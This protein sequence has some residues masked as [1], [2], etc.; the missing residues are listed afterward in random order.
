[1]AG[2]N[3]VSGLPCV[4]GGIVPTGGDRTRGIG[5]GEV[6]NG[7]GTTGGV[8]NTA[9]S[10]TYTFF[11]FGN[12]AKLGTL[13][14]GGVLT[15]QPKYGYLMIDGIDPLF[16]N[17]QNSGTA[18]PGQ[19]AVNGQPL[20]Y[21]EIPGCATDP[22][23]VLPD[24]TTT[25]IWGT[26]PSYP[27]L[28]DGTYPAWSELRMLCNTSDPNCTTASDPAGAEG[29]IQN[30]QGDIHFHRLGGVP[31]ML[32]FSDATAGV[33]SFS[34]PFGDVGFVRQHFTYRLSQT[35]SLLPT[36]T[37]THESN[38]QVVFQSEACSGGASPGTPK[39]GPTP[40]DECGG[41]AGGRIVP[42]GSV[43]TGVLQ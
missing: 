35:G 22:A 12:V 39:T 32:P 26:N 41:D 13:N 10:M 7:V 11:S 9:D 40:S 14:V 8:L 24:C 43:A 38:P 37:S 20:T 31:D 6:V 42:A 15:K 17:Y 25:G 18:N 4:A 29:L 34:P 2:G 5:T 36:P 21:G 33:N 1:V 27:H 30:L 28:R 16:D 19:P 3:P 23:N